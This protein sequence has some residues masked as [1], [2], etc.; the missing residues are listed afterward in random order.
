VKRFPWL[1]VIVATGAALAM[2]EALRA[3]MWMDEIYT[4]EASRHGLARAL[5]I[6]RA[7]VHPPLHFIVTAL[8]VSAGAGSDFA[9]RL[10]SVLF[11]AGAIV[12]TFLLARDMFGRGA[13]LVAAAFLAIHPTHV[14]FSQEVRSYALLWMLLVFALWLAWRWTLRGDRA[15]AIG[16]VC[17]GAL[18]L[19]TH[20]FA[21]IALAFV[22]LGGALMLLGDRRR[23]LPW[24]GLHAAVAVLFAPQLAVFLEQSA[25]LQGSHWIRPPH[26]GQLVSWFRHLSFGSGYLIPVFAVLLA[27]PLVRAGQHRAAA[28][29]WIASAGPV[30]FSYA[31]TLAGGHL[32]NVRYMYFALPA[33]CALLA[34]GATE[35]RR[36]WLRVAVTAGLL[37]VGARAMAIAKPFAEARILAGVR[38]HIE[39]DVAPGDVIFCADTHTLLFFRRYLPGTRVRLVWTEPVL[40]YYEGKLVIPDSLVIGPEAFARRGALGTRW[41]AARVRHGGVPTDHAARLFED[42]ASTVATRDGPAEW[43]GPTPTD[44]AIAR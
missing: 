22:G 10:P 5:E 37:L 44:T 23:I 27:A 33:F 3:P 29:L 2:R 42:A 31:A 41:W 26:A 9:L 18:A 1:A 39:R 34:A 14:H 8:W 17:V 43:W 28:L 32:F 4:L 19:Y 6:S 38:V 40:P 36:P 20:Y 21:G 16:Y 12:G 35:V 11:G 13:G 24:I 30:L 15:S 7:D 25:R